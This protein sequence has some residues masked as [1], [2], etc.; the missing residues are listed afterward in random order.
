MRFDP[1]LCTNF[2]LNIMSYQ[3]FK[4]EYL[5]LC[6]RH[7]RDTNRKIANDLKK[8]IKELEY[9]I[10]YLQPKIKEKGYA[11]MYGDVYTPMHLREMQTE[12]EFS[13]QLLTE[14]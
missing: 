7:G 10:E 14:I 13:K 8:D 11:R 5:Y 3:V 4:S 9:R 2:K 12:L 1:S 6:S